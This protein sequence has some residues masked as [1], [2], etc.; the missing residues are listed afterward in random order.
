[1]SNA[2]EIHLELTYRSP[3]CTLCSLAETSPAVLF[4][5]HELYR[6]GCSVWAARER[7]KPVF[8]EANIALPPYRTL[9]VHLEAHTSITPA[10]ENDQDYESDYFEL[11]KLF[12]DLLT[13]FDAT[14]RNPETGELN[15]VDARL[16]TVLRLVSELRQMIKTLSEIRTSEKLFSTVLS[17]H[18]HQ[19]AVGIAVPVTAALRDLLTLIDASAPSNVLTARIEEYLQQ[20]LPRAFD[21]ITRET[22]EAST[23][24]Y[25]LH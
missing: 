2:G 11:R 15:K 23:N 6:S 22:L 1:M 25:R 12:K 17:N 10:A 20:E 9:Q 13:M 8:D 19:M 4:V 24:Q 7:I 3:K 16:P 21:E 14:V 5:V 18:S